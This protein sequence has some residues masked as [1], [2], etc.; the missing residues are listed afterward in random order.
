MPPNQAPTVFKRS[1]ESA[2]DTRHMEDRVA[3]PFT[4][5]L[6]T[7]GCRVLIISKL[8]AQLLQCA[9]SRV[10]CALP[11]SKPHNVKGMVAA[12]WLCGCSVSVWSTLLRHLKTCWSC[13]SK[14]KMCEFRGHCPQEEI[15]SAG[16]S[17]QQ[18]QPCCLH[19]WDL[20]DHF[21]QSVVL[22]P[23]LGQEV[24]NVVRVS[25]WCPHHFE[26]LL[27]CGQS[28]VASPHHR[29]WIV[30]PRSCR[31]TCCPCWLNATGIPQFGSAASELGFQQL[32][33]LLHS[34][35]SA[36]HV[37]VVQECEEILI[38]VQLQP[39]L[40]VCVDQG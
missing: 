31:Q 34:G 27:C 32:E 39:T 2:T 13:L 37:H 35:W 14:K 19:I 28:F 17:M 40:C 7:S 11:N 30:H 8:S 16:C 3:T 12:S 20:W 29:L 10:L 36:D 9:A 24:S 22:Q 26:A 5:L 15:C 23:F 6:A 25:H 33:H 38:L 21:E 18:Q 4:T 1:A